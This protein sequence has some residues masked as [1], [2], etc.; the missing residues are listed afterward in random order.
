MLRRILE[1]QERYVVVDFQNTLWKS[2][3]A[4]PGGGPDLCRADGYPTGHIFRF[5][6]TIYKWK[7]DFQGHLVFCYE[8][9]ERQRYEI[10]PEYK[11]G[12]KR[13]QEFNPGPDVMRL[14]SLIRCTELRPVGAEADDAIAAFIHRKPDALHLVLSSD[15]DLWTLRGPNVQIVSFQEILTEEDI[16]KSCTKHYGVATPKSITLAKALFGDKSD[17]LPGVPRLLKKHVSSVLE[18]AT[19]PDELF[20]MLDEVPVKTADKIREHEEHIRKMY[21][22]VQLRPE[23]KVKRRER[24]GDERA[25][26][27]FVNEFECSSLQP[28]AKLLCV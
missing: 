24:E 25:L 11:A 6:R 9:Q 23:V 27:E 16:Q 20:T 3:M 7:R 5:F 26:R 19:D 2:W 15:K 8:G 14:L 4:K 12:R 18:K 17:G 10:F 28:M 1:H 22:V 21:S 13:D